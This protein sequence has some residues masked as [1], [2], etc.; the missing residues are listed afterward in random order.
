MVTFQEF[1]IEN[2]GDKSRV[3][4]AL[5]NVKSHFLPY[6]YIYIYVVVLYSSAPLNCS[7]QISFDQLHF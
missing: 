6:V 7:K 4:S 5:L 2:E 1:E 3:Y